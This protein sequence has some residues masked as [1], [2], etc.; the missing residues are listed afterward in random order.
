MGNSKDWLLGVKEEEPS[1]N[2]GSQDCKTREEI[3][4]LIEIGEFGKL[5]QIL[6]WGEEER[7]ERINVNRTLTTCS[8]FIPLCQ[9][10]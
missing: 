10:W 2:S 4:M 9:N 7:E 6:G 3:L 1:R 8:T 5:Y